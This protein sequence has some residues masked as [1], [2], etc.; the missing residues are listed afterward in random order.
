MKQLNII[1]SAGALL[2]VSMQVQAGDIIS[3]ITSTSTEFKVVNSAEAEVTVNARK[4]L[5]AGSVANKF[6]LGTWSARVTAGT[7]AYRVNRGVN[8]APAGATANTYNAQGMSSNSNDATKKIQFLITSGSNSTLSD[9]DGWKVMPQGVVSTS[10]D[11]KIETVSNQ[12]LLAGRYP[13][14]IDVAAYA[15]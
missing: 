3:S 7:L 6:Q 5:A 8:P 4:D 12:V 10:S 15:F 1:T 14:A 9:I 11:A 13:I 2:L